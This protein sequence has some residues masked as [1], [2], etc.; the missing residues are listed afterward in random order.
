MKLFLD[1]DG[2]IVD[3]IGGAIKQHGL[4]HSD[5]MARWPKGEWGS[6]EQFGFKD[7]DEFWNPLTTEFWANLEF[8]KEAPEILKVVQPYKPTLLTSPAF[9]GC[10]GKQLWIKKNLPKYF[11]SKQ[12]L[13]GPAKSAVAS[14]DAVLIDDSDANAE[15][16]TKAGGWVILIPRIWNSDYKL[17]DQDI[18]LMLSRRLKRMDYLIRYG[19]NLNDSK[20]I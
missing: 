17:V 11:Y 4:D 6:E 5:M 13:I 18:P 1:L 14:S 9:G 20:E 3:F 7:P 16:F 10:D 12:Y 19:F 15:E 2:V 8:T